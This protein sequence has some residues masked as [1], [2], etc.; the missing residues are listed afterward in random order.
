MLSKTLRT[1]LILC[2]LIHPGFAAELP[3]V[4]STAKDLGMPAI[5]GVE[6][7]SK[8]DQP[9]QLN[10]H[11]PDYAKGHY[12]LDP[13]HANLV[14]FVSH[15]G[16]SRQVGRFNTLSSELDFDPND[17]GKS[18][19]AVTIQAGSLDMGSDW[20]TRF[21]Q[22]PDL[23]DSAAYP[24]IHFAG[25]SL[26]NLTGNHGELTGILS[27]H[28][29]NRPITL[30]VTLN[31]AKLNPFAGRYDIGFSASG[32]FKRSDFGLTSWP[33]LVGDDLSLLIEVEYLQTER[34][35]KPL[36]P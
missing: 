15:A 14:F 31:R 4:P 10:W 5:T 28:G 19:L 25:Q 12:Q 35:E 20:L 32:S 6:A 33:G 9:P 23:L 1:L 11:L 30:A 17:P 2:W 27:L 3:S 16:L 21:A 24:T 22:S 8:D 13:D 18:Q 29:A 36:V 26:S 34:A 7:E